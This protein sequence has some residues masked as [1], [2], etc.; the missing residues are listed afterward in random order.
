MK[1]TRFLGLAAGLV[2]LLG[3]LGSTAILELSLDEIVVQTDQVVYGEIVENS[4]HKVVSADG[5]TNYYTTLK[6]EG[7][8]VGGSQDLITVDIVYGGGFLNEEEGVWNSEAPSATETEVGKSIVAFYKWQDDFAGDGANALYNM[9]GG[10]FRTDVGP[11]G[12]VVLGR[13]KGYAVDRNLSLSDLD[14][15]VQSIRSQKQNR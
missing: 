4:V 12:T 9:H 14:K 13:G 1:K 10:L 11:S 5:E 8:L 2:A 7:R 6:V 3:S 15:E